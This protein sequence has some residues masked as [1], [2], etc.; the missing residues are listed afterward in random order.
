MATRRIKFRLEEL[1]VRL[2]RVRPQID[3]AIFGGL[4]A[5]NLLALRTSKK[6][7][8]LNGS[9][10]P[11]ATKLTNR[12]GKLS[13]SVRVVAPKKRNGV[14]SSGLKAGG[15]GVPYAAIHEFGGRTRPHRIVP[16]KA[17]VLSWR[18]KSGARRFARSVNHPGSNIPARPYLLPALEKN[19]KQLEKQIATAVEVAFAKGLGG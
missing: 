2:R 4:R 16:R 11:A 17:K 3:K 9:G 10:A 13:R 1:G 8:F 7:F 19:L 15:V 6:E 18:S 14:Y 5:W 12:T